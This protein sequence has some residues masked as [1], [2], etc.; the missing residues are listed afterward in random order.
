MKAGNF[1][2]ALFSESVNTEF[3][4]TIVLDE[5]RIKPEFTA[6]Y[7]GTTKIKSGEFVPGLYVWFYDDNNTSI[8]GLRCQCPPDIVL[9]NGDCDLCL[10]RLE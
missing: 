4:G 8:E 7:F 5:D 1:I 6:M 3:G 2:V 9:D 10:W